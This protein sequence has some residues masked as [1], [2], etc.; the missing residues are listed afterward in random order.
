MTN[1]S[2]FL[3]SIARNI[4]PYVPGEQPKDR[5]YTK[6]NT[7]ENPY[8]PA[9]EVQALLTQRGGE[10]LSLYPDP[11]NTELT[12]KM[13]ETYG[14]RPEQVFAG[15]GSDEVLAYAFMA[16][17]DAGDTVY[18]PDI[19][20]GFYQVY[21][22]LFGL[23]AR[24]LPLRE[25]F[26]IELSDYFGLD[27]N[28]FLANP[29]A[30]TGICLT[31][32]EIQQIL[33]NNP[34]RLVVVDEAYIDFSSGQTM[35]PYIHQYN[36]L[37]VVQTF[38]KSRALAG[39]RLG[40]GFGNAALMDGLNRIKYS[41]NPYNIDRISSDVGVASLSNPAYFSTRVAK[42]VETRENTQKALAALGFEVLPSE[43]NFLFATHPKLSA[44]E[45]Y[46]FLRDNGVLVRYF[47]KERIDE[48]LRITIGTEEDMNCFLKVVAE[49]TKTKTGGLP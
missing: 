34:N 23:T 27:G 30:P 15:G 47:P 1:L 8:P 22:N 7:N 21:A 6:L 11:D 25:D 38:S 28:I 24:T 29:N 2:P 42:I 33:D 36:N 4:S 31:V 12:K 19:T 20:Y 35:I 49:F 41:F 17:F 9:P 32:P 43:T 14:L 39:M 37:L 10:D 48:Y 13:A 18:F 40:F 26:T 46:G 44:K 3:G 5:R 16:F 45:L